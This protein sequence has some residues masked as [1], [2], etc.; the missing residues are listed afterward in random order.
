MRN[1]E[2]EQWKRKLILMEPHGVSQQER[3]SR[4]Y[5]EPV[6]RRPLAGQPWG[7]CEYAA[8]TAALLLLT[9]WAIA[10][11]EWQK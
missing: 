3:P 9:T 7:A 11:W 4:A 1:H 8:L 6:A 2:F 10:I 5:T